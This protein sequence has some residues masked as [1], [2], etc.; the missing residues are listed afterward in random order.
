[1]EP[2]GSSAPEAQPLVETKKRG[3][4]RALLVGLV[5]IIVVLAGALA[6]T[7]LKLLTPPP[8]APVGTFSVQSGQP[9]GVQGQALRCV[10]ANLKQGAKARVHFG[11]GQILATSD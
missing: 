6:Y 2:S 1:M 10:V 7:P 9:T 3:R 5:A 8:T 4:S 11:D